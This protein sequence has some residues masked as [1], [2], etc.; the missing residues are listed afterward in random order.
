MPGKLLANRIRSVSFRVADVKHALSVPLHMNR[1]M[2]GILQEVRIWL[3]S[4]IVQ[5]RDPLHVVAGFGEMWHPSAARHGSLARIVGGQ[6]QL[7]VASVVL[8]K[9]L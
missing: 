5:L 4:S 2:H 1:I 6:G 3:R 7:H 8:H 9:L